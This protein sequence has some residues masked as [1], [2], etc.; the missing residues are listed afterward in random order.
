MTYRIYIASLSDYNAGILYGRWIDLEGKTEDDLQDEINAILEASPYTRQYGDIAEEWAI[1]DY[2]LGGIRIGEYESL[3][4]VLKIADALDDHGEALAI[5]VNDLGNIDDALETFEDAYLGEYDSFLD[6]ATDL[7][8]ELYG[9][10]L[11]DPIGNYIDYHAFARDLEA[12]GYTC[13]NGHVF[14]P[15]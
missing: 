7:F 6:F 9:H 1:H 2:E 14:Q 5:Y 12:E 8:S 10:N 11:D 13:E 4:Q 3:E 15:V